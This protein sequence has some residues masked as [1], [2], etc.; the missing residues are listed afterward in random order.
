VMLY[1]GYPK[2]T[3][4]ERLGPLPAL[5]AAGCCQPPAALLHGAQPSEAGLVLPSIGGVPSYVMHDADRGLR[6]LAADTGQPRPPVAPDGALA[7]AAVFAPGAPLRYAGEVHEDRWT[8][9][10]GLA[11]HRPLHR[12]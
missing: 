11:L 2:L 3:P 4:W 8:H 6:V 1:V 12:I 9:A 10:R 7:E 5:S